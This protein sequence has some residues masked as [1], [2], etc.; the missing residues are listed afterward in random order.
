MGW[1]SKGNSKTLPAQEGQ[2]GLWLQ[3]LLGPRESE[4]FK[5]GPV[6]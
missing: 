6:C 5:V 3:T 1:G 2:A 4:V